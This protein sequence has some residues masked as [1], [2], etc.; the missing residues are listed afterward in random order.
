MVFAHVDNSPP[1]RAF[2]KPWQPA[3][4]DYCFSDQYYFPPPPGP[5]SGSP[6]A[7]S[8]ATIGPK[9]AVPLV[10]CVLDD[11]EVLLAQRA[12]EPVGRR[13]ADR[14]ADAVICPFAEQ[15][16][17]ASVGQGAGIVVDVVGVFERQ[18]GAA[19][20][21][22]ERAQLRHHAPFIGCHVGQWDRREAAGKGWPV[23]RREVLEHAACER[24][25]EMRVDVGEARHDHLA[26]AVKSFGGGVA[27]QQVGARTDRRDAIA[28]NCNRAVVVDGVAIIDGDDRGIV[29]NGRQSI[30][31]GEPATN[32]KWCGSCVYFYGQVRSWPRLFVLREIPILTQGGRHV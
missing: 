3:H 15:R 27:R 5:V 13:I 14:G 19:A 16:P 20:H 6:P 9:L 28:F 1:A 4:G 24:H 23:R 26:P 12:I 10:E 29:D 31:R 22:L 7:D 32:K 30:P 18:R 17:Q 11:P 21:R 2:T 25:G 8:S